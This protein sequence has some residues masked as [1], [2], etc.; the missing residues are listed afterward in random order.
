M[1]LEISIETFYKVGMFSFTIIALMAIINFYLY[2]SVNNLFSKISGI[3]S[4]IFDIALVFMFNYLRNM[5]NPEIE[6]VAESEDIDEIMKQLRIKKDKKA[7]DITK[8]K[9]IK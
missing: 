8:G 5:S 9:K 1:K 2:W 7:Q 3:A 6:T 4:I